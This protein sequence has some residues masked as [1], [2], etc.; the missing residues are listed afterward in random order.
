MVLTQW[1][2]DFEHIIPNGIADMTLTLII[3]DRKLP[4]KGARPMNKGLKQLDIEEL[5]HLSAQI[6]A[7]TGRVAGLL[8]PDNPNESE[9]LTRKI[10]QWAINQTVVIENNQNNKQDVA[11]IF[12][13]V[14]DRIWRQLPT[15]AQN[16]RITVL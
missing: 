4:H 2:V 14:G 13:K 12:N 7:D 1:K 10:G 11:L 15:Y 9:S 5:Y 6:E 16:L 8:F 3:S